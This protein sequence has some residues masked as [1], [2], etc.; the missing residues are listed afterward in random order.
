MRQ[1]VISGSSFVDS[2]RGSFY[3]EECHLGAADLCLV[4][5]TFLCL[6]FCYLRA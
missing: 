2:L 1:T 3:I 6:G 5:E 4:F